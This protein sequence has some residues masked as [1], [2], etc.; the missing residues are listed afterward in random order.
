[1]F[2]LE[3]SVEGG[4]QKP[5]SVDPYPSI[6]STIYTTIYHIYPMHYTPYWDPYVDGSFEKSGALQC[7]AQI[8]GPLL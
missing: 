4:F 5:R 1:M 8:A 2:Q 7:G 3:R 6:P